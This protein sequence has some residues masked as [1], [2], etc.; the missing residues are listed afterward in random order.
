MITFF[1]YKRKTQKIFKKI[2]LIFLEN[3]IYFFL[4]LSQIET[5]KMKNESFQI[6][7]T[8]IWK[9]RWKII[10]TEKI[11]EL[12]EQTMWD[13]YTTNRMYKIFYYLK[14][15][16]YIIDLKKNF[17]YVKLPEDEINEEY[18][19]D[20]LYRSILNK[21]IKNLAKWKR[22]IWGLK[23]LE[24]AMGIYTTPDEILIVNENKQGIENLILEKKILFKTYSSK[25]KNLYAF[26][27][28]ETQP[29][30]IEKEKITI[31]LPELAILETLYNTSTIQKNYSEDLI[32]KWLRKNKKSFNINII[33]RCLKENKH[34]SSINRLAELAENVD[35][36]IAKQLKTIIKK[37]WYLLN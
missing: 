15:R 6:I 21:Q 23:A 26:F 3:F 16:W 5:Q 20:R 17:Y 35:H 18:I 37:Y 2:V 4:L 19:V 27:H 33:E 24:I 10:T 1:N 31:A 28:K 8:K 12:I 14:N 9:Y 32:K 30:T 13:S 34:N 29:I 36:E 25:K 22:Y 11:R 7:I